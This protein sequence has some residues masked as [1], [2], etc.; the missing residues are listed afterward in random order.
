VHELSITQS[1]LELALDHGR[2]AGGGRI[3]RLHVVI[4]ELS[5][6]VDDSVAFYWDLISQGTAA[7]G[8]ELVFERI[9]AELGCNRCGCRYQLSQSQLACHS[10][11]STDIS[12]LAGDELLLKSID[13]TRDSVEAGEGAR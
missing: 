5:T 6:M 9:P 8:A 10:C 3:E 12:I 2:K 13:L 11:G 7:E 1:L 4:G